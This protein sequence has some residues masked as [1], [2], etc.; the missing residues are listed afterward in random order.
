MHT[1]F[2]FLFTFIFLSEIPL[3]A[4][5]VPVQ[6]SEH[7][8]KSQNVKSVSAFYF[9]SKDTLSIDAKLI[10]K[11]DFDK[12]GKITN[13]YILSLW[14]GVSYSVVST[15][16]YQAENITE[17][18]HE[19]AILNLEERDE[20]Y[21]NSF[22]DT[23]LNEKINYTYNKEGQLIKKDIYSLSTDDIA[24]TISPSQTILYQYDSGYLVQEKSSSLNNRVFNKNFSNEYSYDLHGNLVKITKTYGGEMELQRITDYLYDI[25]NRMVEEKVVDLVIP[26]NNIHFRYQ[27]D[28][29]GKLK[30]KLIFDKELDDF[31]IDIT[32]QY[33]LQGHRISGEKDVEFTYY[34]NGLI[35][36]EYWVD[37]I[38][39]QE[40]YFVTHY[41]Y[42]Q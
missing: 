37:P 18:F 20:E 17:E 16:K 12:N 2:Y 9:Y 8:L 32:Y 34:D 35:N 22:G 6:N 15:Y 24:D 27:Y 14:E 42:L 4:Q 40:F 10:L 11:K 41:I 29:L 38:S 39:D 31:V 5:L 30:N 1:K 25:E 26:R 13:K 19:Q 36:S 33:D 23:P 7:E 21:I 28:D 3:F